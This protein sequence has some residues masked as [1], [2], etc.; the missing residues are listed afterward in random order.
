MNDKN[1]QAPYSNR[2][3]YEA[4]LYVIPIAEIFF[5]ISTTGPDKKASASR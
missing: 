4:I 1:K 5:L 2:L 3:E